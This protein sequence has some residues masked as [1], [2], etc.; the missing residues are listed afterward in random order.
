MEPDSDT[1]TPVDEHTPD[2]QAA[3]GYVPRLRKPHPLISRTTCKAHG[4][5]R[6]GRVIR[7][8]H[9]GV[10]IRVSK[11]MFRTA[12]SIMDMFFKE[13]EKR[14]IEISNESGYNGGTFAV[15]GRD[16]CAISISE[17]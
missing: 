1:S 9:E 15:R 7:N 4:C 16:R 14:E 8:D 10:D 13:L 11:A 12:L 17:H 2:Q 5:S 3:Q 6:P